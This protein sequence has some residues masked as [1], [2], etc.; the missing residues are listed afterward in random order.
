MVESTCPRMHRSSQPCFK[1]ESICR[2]CQAEDHEKER[3]KQR[4]HQLDIEREIKQKQYAKQLQEIQDQMELERRVLRERAEQH[5]RDNV[6]RQHRQDLE[7]IRGLVRGSQKAQGIQEPLPKDAKAFS[8]SDTRPV[9][10]DPGQSKE[11]LRMNEEN[12]D[13]KR[14]GAREEWVQQ[15]ELEGAQ[16]E[17]LDDL[18]EMVGL[19]DVKLKFLSIKSRVDTAIRQNIDARGERFGATLLGNP[20]TGT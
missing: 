4:D 10:P 6:L 13:T 2:K 11:T 3:K 9:D 20:G 18:M 14:S 15:K 17:A 5:D 19:E 16:N 8:A 7:N 1:K 12:L